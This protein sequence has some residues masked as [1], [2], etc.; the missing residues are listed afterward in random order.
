VIE[1]VT[2]PLSKQFKWR[3]DHFSGYVVAW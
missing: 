3:I 2:I 1:G